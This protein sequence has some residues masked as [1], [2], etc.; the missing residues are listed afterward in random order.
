MPVESLRIVS[1]EVR[2]HST[3][4]GRFTLRQ[5]LKFALRV[6]CSAGHRGEATPTRFSF[7]GATIEVVEVVDAWFAPDHR[8]FKIRGDDGACYILRNDVASGWWQLTFY[9]ATKFVV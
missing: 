6:E 8:Y 3:R 4:Q 1:A 9:D 7:G 5:E 2:E